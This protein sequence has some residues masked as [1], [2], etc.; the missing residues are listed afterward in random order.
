MSKIAIV[1]LAVIAAAILV[2]F[3][4]RIGVLQTD[5]AHEAAFSGNDLS[6]SARSD[7]TSNQEVDRDLLRQIKFQLS[8]MDARLQAL[9]QRL[10]TLPPSMP[11]ASAPMPTAPPLQLPDGSDAP[12]AWIEKLDPGKKAS[13]ESAFEAAAA[14][15]RSRMPPPGVAPDASTL[16]AARENLDRELAGRLRSI[17]S[18][19]EFDAYLSSLPAGLRARIEAGKSDNR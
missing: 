19:Q 6:G 9:E 1:G 12:W 4:M 15:A 17:L 11:S 18:P 14:S 2:M 10:P 16:E 7:R 3:F 8:S 5:E 13:V